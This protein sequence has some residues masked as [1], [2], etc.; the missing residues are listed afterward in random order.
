[1]NRK[2]NAAKHV[3][4]SYEQAPDHR[5]LRSRAGSAVVAGCLA[6]SMCPAIALAAQPAQDAFQ[7]S[8]QPAMAQQGPEMQ[9]QGG[10][11]DQQMGIPMEMNQDQATAGDAVEPAGVEQGGTF[12]PADMEQGSAPQFAD[13]EQGG[14]SGQF[15][16]MQ[17]SSEMDNQ[18]R[19][20]IMEEYGFGGQAD[21]PQDGTAQGEGFGQMP[22]MAF[23]N[24]E[25]APEIPDGEPNIQA[26]IDST[27]D[28]MLKYKDAD[29]DSLDF[30][31][32]AF[33]AELE[34]FVKESTAQRLEMFAADERPSAAVSSDAA[35]RQGSTFEAPSDLPAPE[36]GEGAPE[37]PANP[38]SSI[39]NAGS[40]FASSV[41]DF[42][43]SMFGVVSK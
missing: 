22:E 1:M 26:I 9:Q 6:L 43:M 27:R 40:T 42:L 16:G 18:I 11:P 5:S 35:T 21:A 17:Q 25:E 15:P 28:I 2:I 34:S 7:Q 20:L 41:V 8:G 4:A 23:G 19:Q 10:T 36:E 30:S 29:L 3:T 31:D 39:E 12:Q 38:G 37:A 13:M 14:M 32:E 33:R 24:P